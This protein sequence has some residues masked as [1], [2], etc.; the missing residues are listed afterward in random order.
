MNITCGVPQGSILEP[1]FFIVYVDD[2]KY[3]L[4]ECNHLLYADDTVLYLTGELE[5][6]TVALQNDLSDFKIWCDR[7]Q[8]TMNIKKTNYIIFGLKPKTRKI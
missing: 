3:S 5:R 4:K 7:N 1:L 8:L 6:S 2:M